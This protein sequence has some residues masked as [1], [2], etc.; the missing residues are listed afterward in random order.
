MDLLETVIG[1]HMMGRYDSSKYR[2]V[3][4]VEAIKKN[5]KNFE[6]FLKTVEGLPALIC[7]MEDEAYF[8]GDHEKHLKPTKEHL[9]NLVRYIAAKKFDRVSGAG[10]K[11]EALYGMYGDAEREKAKNEALACIDAVYDEP[12]LPKAWYIFEGATNPDIYMEGEDYIILCE[13]KWT[14]SHITEKTTHLQG[15]DEQRNQMIR[16][17]QGA[18]CATDKKIYAFYIVDENC[19]YKEQLTAQAF[20][21]QLEKETIRT[22]ETEKKKILNAFYGYT[23]WQKIKESIPSVVFLGKK[24][25]DCLA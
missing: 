3:P 5:Q 23:T 1:R 15:K 20:A 2:V 11:R 16:H 9:R 24:E 10:K 12:M 7:P 13:G 18:L 21:E 14:E 4:L 6:A 25:I 17:I 22:D 19:A 8:Y